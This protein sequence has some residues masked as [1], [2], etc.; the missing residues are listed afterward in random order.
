MREGIVQP[1]AAGQKI[2]PGGLP[3]HRRHIIIDNVNNIVHIEVKQMPLTGNFEPGVYEALKRG[4]WS[5]FVPKE[6]R[7]NIGQLV[8]NGFRVEPFFCVGHE[9]EEY[10]VLQIVE[11]RKN[12]LINE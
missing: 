12:P 5:D 10:R 6:F 8:A 7:P 9:N 1:G 2:S 4:R 11:L 3:A